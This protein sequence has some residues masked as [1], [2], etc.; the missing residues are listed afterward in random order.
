MTREAARYRDLVNVA[1][2]IIA[3]CAT[4]A[5]A[6]AAFGSW[7]AA[8]KMAAIERGR[9]H[10]ELTPRFQITCSEKA[11]DASSADLRVMLTGGGLE[12]LDE[13][14][15]TILDDTNQDYWAHGPPDDVTQEQASAFVWG[16]CGVPPSPSTVGL[17]A[18]DEHGPKSSARF[19]T[20][21]LG[22]AQA[23]RSTSSPVRARHRG[24]SQTSGSA[25][26]T[27]GSLFPRRGAA[28]A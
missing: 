5:A 16:P 13:V 22:K 26:T 7:S 6:V 19:V 11:N 21:P 15:V 12:R 4:I 23:G 9:R 25:T 28:T 18:P 3:L 17:R 27:L 2:T 8:T 20:R 14:T 24:V 1:I 10:E